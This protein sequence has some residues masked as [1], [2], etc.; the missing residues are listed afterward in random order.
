MNSRIYYSNVVKRQMYS[1]SK[2]ARTLTLFLLGQHE[3]G[4]F[5]VSY[6]VGILPRDYTLSSLDAF[7]KYGVLNVQ[8][9]TTFV[10]FEFQEEVLAKEEG[11]SS[12]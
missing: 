3:A 2:P 4:H 6:L 10:D 12:R 11:S 1:S 9:G 7:R 8:A 5:L